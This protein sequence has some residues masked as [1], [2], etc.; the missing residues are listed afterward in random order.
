MKN[1]TTAVGVKGDGD[2]DGD[3]W[4][5]DASLIGALVGL[6]LAARVLGTGCDGKSGEVAL[7]HL[8]LDGG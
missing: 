6:A 1:P 7:A 2:G 4:G 3:C 8:E 5:L